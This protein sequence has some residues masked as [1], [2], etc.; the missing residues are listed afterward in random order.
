MWSL[1]SLFTT[2]YTD[3]HNK[4]CWSQV[5]NHNNHDI[6]RRIMPIC[7]F[8]SEIWRKSLETARWGIT[9]CHCESYEI[10]AIGTTFFMS[11]VVKT[12]VTLLVLET[13]LVNYI[14]YLN[15]YNW[16][17][18]YTPNFILS[19]TSVIKRNELAEVYKSEN[20]EYRFFSV[21][22]SDTISRTSQEYKCVSSS[23]RTDHEI[24]HFYSVETGYWFRS[25]TSMK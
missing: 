4:L 11:D 13:I 10:R 2:H 7:W 16:Q 20:W 5:S 23:L 3:H 21:F 8:S 22:N 15:R 14:A 6:I 18:C 17:L 9:K 1:S 19:M 24:R 12:A 25:L